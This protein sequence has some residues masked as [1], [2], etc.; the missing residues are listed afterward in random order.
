[1]AIRGFS[2]KMSDIAELALYT[3]RTSHSRFLNS[4]AWDEDYL[5]SAIHSH[6]IKTI[7]QKAKETK[8]PIYIII[9]DTICE[10]TKPSSKAE[11]SIYGASF[12][13]SHLKGKCVYGHQFVGCML[14]C[15]DLVLPYDIVLYEKMTDG[16]K[17]KSKIEIA[18]NI[19]ESLPQPPYGGYVVTD[20]WYSCKALL[21]AAKSKGYQFIGGLIVV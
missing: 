17:T 21:E 12:H 10:K 6:V 13:K 5:L 3:H 20:S 15:G 9:D 4:D 19:I 2:G 1:M 11:S 18:Q 7:W 16:S 8:E 14:R